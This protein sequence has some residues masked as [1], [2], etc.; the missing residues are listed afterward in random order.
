MPS[1]SM[2]QTVL[3]HVAH[4]VRSW[5]DAWS[6]YA[7]QLGA[8]WISGGEG[9]GF[10]PA[11]LRFANGSRIELLRPHDTAANDFLARFLEHSG[12][13]AHHLTFKVPDI[14]LAIDAA[15][16][17][18]FDPIGVDLSDPE[19]KEAFIHPKQATGIVVQLA[20]ATGGWSNPP[21]DDFPTERRRRKDGVGPV[22]PASL[23][24]VTH[25]VADLDAGANL[26][27]RLLGGVVEDRGTDP[28]EEWIDLVWDCPLA[29][30]LISPT[31]GPESHELADWLGGRNGRLHHLLMAD[32]EPDGLVDARPA[33]PGAP[34]LGGSLRRQNPWIVEPENNCGVRL[35]VAEL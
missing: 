30:R 26:F 18:G 17:A 11:Q 8:E 28:G 24:R 12:P 13:G 23:R 6:L 34:G 20:E 9:I 14:L 1:P 29:V 15:R 33:R 25:A 31:A 10:A 5:Q 27:G 35:V 4:A 32:E 7:T 19:W 22:R 3:D 2:S 16:Q 21:P